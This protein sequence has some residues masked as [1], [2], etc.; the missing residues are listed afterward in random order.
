MASHNIP[1]IS[2]P[3]ETGDF[4]EANTRDSIGSNPAGGRV[5]E[6]PPS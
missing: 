6:E 4:S 3:W 2:I 5:L 1:S